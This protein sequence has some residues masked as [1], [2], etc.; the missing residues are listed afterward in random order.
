MDKH[1][2]SLMDRNSPSRV[3]VPTSQSISEG[4][5]SQPLLPHLVPI[6]CRV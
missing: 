4:K 3:G 5:E 2:E 1:L 6:W